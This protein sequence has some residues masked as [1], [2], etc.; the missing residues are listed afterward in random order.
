MIYFPV[1]ALTL[2]LTSCSSSQP[3]A[4]KQTL[5]LNMSSDAAALDPRTVRL[6]KD[7]TLV[8]HLFEG[9]TRSDGD[10]NPQLALAHSYNISDDGLVY[11][12]YL[13]DATWTNGE[14]ISAEDFVYS[15]KRVLDPDFPTEYAH[16]LYVIKNGEKARAKRCALDQVGVRAL[17]P[18]TLEVTLEKATPYF[19]EL[20]SFPTFFPVNRNIDQNFPLW[21][22]PP[23]KHFVSSGPFKL[24]KWLPTQ[25]IDLQKNETYWDASS[26]FLDKLVISMI[27]DNNTEGL[28]FTKGELD[29]LGQPLSNNICPELLGELR[30]KQQLDSYPIDGTVWFKCNVSKPPFNNRNIRKAFAMAIPREE[31]IHHILQGNQRAAFSPLPPTLSLMSGPSFTENR[32]AAIQ[33]FEA[34]LNE[35]GWVRDSFPHLELEYSQSERNGKIAQFVQQVWQDLFGISVDLKKVEYQIYRQDSRSGHFQIAIA[36]WIA[37]Y[38]DPLSFLEIFLP[39]S[40]INETRWDDPRFDELVRLSNLSRQ[41]ERRAFMAEAEQILTEE[42]PVIPLYHHAF[43]YVKKEGVEGVILSPLGGG[44]FKTARI[45]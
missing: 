38:H 30:A 39:T 18:R 11:T 20:L 42:M 26:V 27:Q 45:R 23:G 9:L 1:L 7:L 19:L 37:D 14:R 31:M 28:L 3:A 15:W 33:L 16:M 17:D 10:G 29:W 4:S 36:E 44:D 41:E 22:S 25:E 6:V 32:E 21:T 2:L 5:H 24:E 34:G 43:D 13:R 8:R 35:M 40:A 12:F